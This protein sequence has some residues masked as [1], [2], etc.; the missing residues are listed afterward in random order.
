MNEDFRLRPD[1]AHHRKTRR[2]M[3]LCGAEGV[4]NLLELLG[5]VTHYRPNGDLS[6]MSV[7]D[8]EMSSMWDGEPG[9]FLSSLL[10]CGFVDGEDMAYCIHDWA[11]HNPYQAK[12][13]ER[14]EIARANAKKRWDKRKEYANKNATAMQ[15]DATCIND[16][17][18]K[19]KEFIISLIAEYNR[20]LPMCRKMD[21]QFLG[22]EVFWIK[23]IWKVFP[24]SQDLPFWTEIFEEV[25]KS[26]WL[27]SKTSFPFLVT[28]DRIKEI[29]AGKYQEAEK[30]QKQ[31]RFDQPKQER[32]YPDA[33]QK[34]GLSLKKHNPKE[35]GQLP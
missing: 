23:E 27:R 26:D 18:T 31:S 9:K 16:S 12:A 35:I 24:E 25:L 30:K 7:D 5:Y 29:K 21:Y 11:E 13:Q 2:L 15:T 34:L 3:K 1:F 14:S 6:G 22:Q 8:I 19:F 17:K 10:Q 4:I 32:N 28:L 20:V 33:P